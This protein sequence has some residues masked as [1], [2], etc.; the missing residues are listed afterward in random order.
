DLVL[1][2]PMRQRTLLTTFGFLLLACVIY[3]ALRFQATKIA[4]REIDLFF[5]TFSAQHPSRL[6]DDLRLPSQSHDE[7]QA[8]VSRHIDAL[9]NFRYSEVTPRLN[10]MLNST[11]V[12]VSWHLSI[13]FS[14]SGHHWHPTYF[15]EYTTNPSKA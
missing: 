10:L 12:E 15:D 5:A 3:F 4:D 13:V 2:R 14:R 11:R 9:R 7:A 8:I 6:I 1:V